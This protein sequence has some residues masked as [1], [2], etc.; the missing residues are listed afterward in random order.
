MKIVALILL[1]S[2]SIWSTAA[3]ANEAGVIRDLTLDQAIRIALTNHP[4]LAEAHANI[5]AARARASAAGKL[6]NPEAVA[7]MESAP[8]SSATASQAEYVAGVSQ[9]IPLGRRLTAA[10]EVEESG[11][12]LREKELEASALSLTKSVRSGFA[13]A[14]YASEMLK[15]QTNLGA[16]LRELLRVTKA[17]VEQ[18]DAPALDLARLEAEE[19]EQRLE[20]KEAAYLHHEALDA[21][22]TALGDFNTPIFSLAGNLEESL[23]LEEITASA[24][25]VEMHPGVAATERAAAAQRARVKLAKA[26]RIPD[27]NLDLFY[28]RLQGTRENAFD[29]GVR[30]P[31]PLFGR[32]RSRVREA[33]SELRAAEARLESV[34]NEIGHELHARE[35]ALERA[36]ETAAT[37]KA[38]VLPKVNAVL[39]GAEARFAAGDISLSELMVIRRDAVTS[40]MKYLEALRSVM[41]AWA[42][43]KF[44]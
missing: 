34:R 20:I 1:G 7:R 39:R 32:T 38:D 40:Q 22:A 2:F 30:V 16:N 21:L 44:G 17:R 35:L 43:L 23:E 5:E 9:T 8:L 25:M 37:L 27:V 36:L 18:G 19:A 14:L 10:R 3:P 42:G 26:E 24:A 28:R 33:E 29:V 4:H 15:A 13:T 31:I 11:V 41:E 6:P 12:R